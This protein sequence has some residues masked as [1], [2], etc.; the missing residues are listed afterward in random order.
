VPPFRF[1]SSRPLLWLAIAVTAGIATG[2]LLPWAFPVAPTMGAAATLVLLLAGTIP[3]RFSGARHPVIPLCCFWALGI[4]INGLAAPVLPAPP[5][6]DPY[7][8]RPRTLFLAEVA[9]PVE[10]YPDRIRLPL[11]L[12]S[13]FTEGR[14]VPVEGGVLVTLKKTEEPGEPWLT[15]D[16]LMV[17]LTLKRFHNFNNPGGYD[18]VRSQAE[19]GFYARAFAADPRFLI[20]VASEPEPFPSVALHVVK[21]RLDRFRQGALCWLQSSLEPDKSALYAALLLG[22][23]N[24]IPRTLQEHINRSG[25]SHLLSISGLHLSMVAMMTFW[26]ACRL[27]RLLFPSVLEKTS[28]KHLALW[29]AILAAVLYAFIAGL[30]TPTWRSLIMLILFFGACFRYHAPDSLSALAA[31][32]LTIL[33]ISPE[34]LRQV[35][36]Q[37]SFAGV[38]GLLLIYPRFQRLRKYLRNERP[39]RDRLPSRIAEPFVDA[40]WV[41]LA[42]NIM[43]LPLTVFH[44]HGFSLAGLAANCLLVPAVGFLVLPL[45]LSSLLLFAVAEMPALPVLK[46]GAFLLGY[47]RDAIIWFSELSWA[48]FWVG[49]VPLIWPTFYFGGL[50]LL[51]GPWGWRKKAAGIVAGTVALCLSLLAP[52]EVRN[53]FAPQGPQILRATFI[54]VGQGTSTL[55]RFP[56]GEAMLVDG[57]GFHDD[58]YDVG[59]SV[60]APFLWTCGIRGLDYVVLSHDHPDHANGLRFILSHFQVRSFWET[61]I[62]DGSKSSTE[63]STIASRRGIRVRRL[64]DI[65]GEHSIGECRVRVLH[66][67]SSYVEERWNKEDLNSVSMVLQIDY[68]NTGV[69]LPGDIDQSVENLLFENH[70]SSG[71]L[72]LNASHHGSAHSNGRILLDRLHPDAM[73]FSCGYDNWFGFP[74]RS[75]LEE[76]RKRKIPYFT[77]DA[78]GAVEAVSDGSQWTLRPTVMQ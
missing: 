15:G 5:S 8:D 2:H 9:G 64:D 1:F 53:V 7:F 60:V 19:R 40:F 32:A 47:C 62:T 33:I 51:L 68:G 55:V 13:A 61:G 25:V 3:G 65:K 6:L 43:V 76:C 50:A 37:L 4:L 63:L 24:L 16:R 42:A 10:F 18:Y 72:I 66:P 54:D 17:R 44:F 20:K 73:V 75:V 35:S 14:T 31:A 39:G 67:T 77:T 29:P 38:L 46:A 58:S 12:H 30:A 21:S 28:D 27:A 48:Y 78:H 71:P 36:F 41:S 45:G 57:G 74:A 34:S 49:T 26:L 52:A 70:V 56:S 59:R 22:Y 11:S 69:I 23:M